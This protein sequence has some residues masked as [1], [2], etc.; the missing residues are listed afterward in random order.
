MRAFVLFTQP[1]EHKTIIVFVADNSGHERQEFPVLWGIYWAVEIPN[2]RFRSAFE[3][4]LRRSC[5]REYMHRFAGFIDADDEREMLNAGC[6]EARQ[7]SVQDAILD[8]WLYHCFQTHHQGQGNGDSVQ[9]KFAIASRTLRPVL[10][11]NYRNRLTRLFRGPQ[12]FRDSP[13]Q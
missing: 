1:A 2:N 7:Y 4:E 8:R 11:D 5:G 6:R 13:G 9:S 10:K 3:Q 12:N